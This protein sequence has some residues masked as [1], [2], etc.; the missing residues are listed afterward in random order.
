M[1]WNSDLVETLELE[2]LMAQAQVTIHSALNRRKAAAPTP[3]RT[4][5]TATTR[6]G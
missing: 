5:P 3:A 2:N 4:F 6:T 1:I